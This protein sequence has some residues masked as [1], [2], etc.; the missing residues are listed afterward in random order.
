MGTFIQVNRFYS[1]KNLIVT[2]N[3]HIFNTNKQNRS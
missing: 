1:S 2:P 3:I